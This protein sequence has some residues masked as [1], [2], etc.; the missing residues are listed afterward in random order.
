VVMHAAVQRGRAAFGLTL[1]AVTY[2]VGLLAWVI[3]VPAVDGETLLG[4]GGLGSL[5]I[6]AQ[7]LLFSLVMWGLLH[8]GCT[9]GSRT[10]THAAQA[11][12]GLYL[13]WSVL[14]ALS[15]AAGAFPAAVLLLLAVAL[16][17]RPDSRAA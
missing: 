15:L 9:I 14:G 4:Y 8:L 2:S 13:A 17:P 12:G 16:T 1:L 10:A 7:P 3:A 6:T 11:L 5:A